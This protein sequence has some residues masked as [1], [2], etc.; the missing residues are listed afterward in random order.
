[1]KVIIDGDKKNIYLKIPAELI[2]FSKRIKTKEDRDWDKEINTLKK[3]IKYL[4]N[5]QC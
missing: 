1:M 5:K 3:R 2:E 4:E